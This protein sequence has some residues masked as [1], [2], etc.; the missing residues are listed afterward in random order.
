MNGRLPGIRALRT[1]EAACRHLNFSKAAT[2]LGLTP[3]AVSHQVKEFEDQIGVPLFRRSARTASLTPA[4]EIMQKAAREAI[5]GL[6]RA[7]GEARRSDQGRRLQI[8]SVNTIASK[9][10]LPRIDKFTQSHPDLDIQIHISDHIRDDARDNSDVLFWWGSGD[11]AGK[12]VDRLYE[13]AIYPVCSPEFIKEWGRPQKPEDLLGTRLIH[14]GWSRDGLVWPDWR[15]WFAAAG[16]AGFKDG[17]GVHFLQTGQALQAAIAGHGVAL[18][19][20]FLTADDI[21]AGR[22]IRLFD[23]PI[24]GPPGHSYEMVSPL[25]VAGNEAVVAFRTWVLAEARETVKAI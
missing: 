8:F 24:G 11:Y 5:E 14:V 20:A 4:G 10:L 12:Q 23:L 22:L 18:G 6:T 16:I 9:W 1:L 17:S 15:E 19:D 13:H 2:E 7:L 21:A 3:A 25:A